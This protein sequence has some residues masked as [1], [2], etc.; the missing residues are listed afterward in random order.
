MHPSHGDGHSLPSVAGSLSSKKSLRTALCHPRRAACAGRPPTGL[1]PGNPADQLDHV[2]AVYGGMLPAGQLNPISGVS[3]SV[4]ISAGARFCGAPTPRPGEGPIPIAP[5]SAS[6]A[7]LCL[8]PDGLSPVC[9]AR[10][11]V[12]LAAP[13]TLRKSQRWAIGLVFAQARPCI[14]PSSEGRSAC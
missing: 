9:G 1:R 2:G 10:V 14:L 4:G 11:A 6:G 13:P 12:L 5:P 3:S 8:T 7:S